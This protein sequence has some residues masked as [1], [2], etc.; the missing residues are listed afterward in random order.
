MARAFKN[1]RRGITAA[2]ETPERELLH[3][4]FSDVIIAL[5][6][7]TS[8]GE[9]ELARMVGITED[10]RPPEDPALAR[11]LP[12][13]GEDE[14]QSAEFRRLTERGI[15]EAKTAH[16]RMAQMDVQSSRLQL[17]PTHAQAFAAALNDVRL[18]LAARLG[19]EDED[20]AERVASYTDWSQAED[21]ESYMAL[22]YH[23]V[24]WLQETLIQALMEQLD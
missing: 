9:D 20:D 3:R 4:L 5:D 11:L 14:E 15:R 22:V 19:I 13:A 24:S 1:T 8:E 16:L 21:V 12:Q 7:E 23:F 18:V 17:D 10:A 6:V 2:L